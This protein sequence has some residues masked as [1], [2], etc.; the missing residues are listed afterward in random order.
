MTNAATSAIVLSVFSS[1]R[2][3]RLPLNYSLMDA[4]MI[5]AEGYCGAAC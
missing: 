1:S 4:V 5:M 2:K 3:R